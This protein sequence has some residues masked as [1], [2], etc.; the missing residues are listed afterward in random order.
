[1]LVLSTKKPFNWL[2]KDDA[3][4]K[5]HYFEIWLVLLLTS[6][7]FVAY[8][9]VITRDTFQS[10]TSC[11]LQLCFPSRGEAIFPKNLG[12]DLI[13]LLFG[14]HNMTR[15]QA[16]HVVDYNQ[17]IQGWHIF[18]YLG[19]EDDLISFTYWRLL[20][21]PCHNMRWIWNKMLSPL[22][23]ICVTSIFRCASIS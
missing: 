5:V 9:G 19:V 4:L 11:R 16:L 7:C 13:P 6:S 3:S 17:V 20:Q 21:F 2:G 18:R 14:C 23:C 10:S 8:P 12:V 22:H 1:M 15:F